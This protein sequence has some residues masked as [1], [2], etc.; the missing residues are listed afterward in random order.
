M[1]KLIERIVIVSITLLGT[2]CVTTSANAPVTAPLSEV[3]RQRDR[4]FDD[5]Q[6]VTRQ[7]QMCYRDLGNDKRFK[8]SIYK[9]FSLVSQ[10]APS[11]QRNDP[12]RV[13]DEMIA[14][15]LTWYALH[16]QC[17]NAMTKG[18][19]GVDSRLELMSIK[20]LQDRSNLFKR[21]VSERPTYGEVN[22]ELDVLKMR[23]ASEYKSWRSRAELDFSRRQAQQD[24]SIEAKRA[25]QEQ[26]DVFTSSAKNVTRF[27]LEALGDLATTELEIAKAQQEYQ[28]TH[29]QPV[30]VPIQ[31]VEPRITNT[32][33][34]KDFRGDINCTHY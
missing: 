16:Q 24:K 13:S 29:P 34:R 33:C 27:L 11:S 26:Q 19:G 4:F 31:P 8:F 9:K 6:F 28:A 3:Q 1:A 5:V 23:E 15:A 22:S 25:T 10:P 17:D 20:W 21:V 2:A 18:Y 30:Y 32:T 7:A 12:E 14:L